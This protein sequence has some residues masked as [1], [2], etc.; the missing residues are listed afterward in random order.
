M[1]QSENVNM[2]VKHPTF[3]APQENF[4]DVAMR[5][6]RYRNSKSPP[7]T[8]P[9]SIVVINP[10]G[11]Q[12]TQFIVPAAS[13]L[14]FS[15]SF[16]THQGTVAP[17]ANGSLQLFA[18]GYDFRTINLAAASGYPIVNLE[19]A[20]YYANAIRPIETDMTDF[21]SQ[22]DNTQSFYPCNSLTVSNPFPF[23]VDGSTSGTLN[24]GTT[25]YLE[26]QHLVTFAT[27]ATGSFSRR[28]YLGDL[29]GTFFGCD[30]DS[31]FG[32]DMNVN[33]N[34]QY[35]Q[36]MGYY[37]AGNGVLTQ[38]GA[39]QSNITLTNVNF[40]WALEQ[41]VNIRNDIIN[42][43]RSGGLKMEIPYT[44]TTNQVAAAGASSL[45]YSF[46]ISKN[47][48]RT[49]KRILFV[50]YANTNSGQLSFCHTNANGAVITNFQ[51]SFD[52]KPLTDYYLNCFNPNNTA[53][54]PGVTWSSPP[55]WADDWREA[56]QWLAGKCNFGGYP[57]YQN[58][59]WYADVW[60]I[61][62]SDAMMAKHAEEN[63]LD[64][65]SLKDLGNHT[66]TINASSP[67][68]AQSTNIYNALGVWMFFFNLYTRKLVITADGFYFDDS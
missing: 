41:N 1:A 63:S 22:R 10:N 26:A 7:T 24:S 2:A 65:F 30:R 16:E 53:S 62:Q 48:G 25:A 55:T 13:T 28:N 21:L 33:I 5:V 44:Y 36:R 15:R 45:N 3:L 49:L 58:Q 67:S 19:Y 27:G 12:Q 34:Y 50:P 64:G 29:K 9:S 32:T 14:N 35:G 8:S 17:V 6:P 54:P 37:S 4:M 68:V 31:C 56:Q 42:K 39:I 66:Y 43:L 46:T 57:S 20:D 11:N 51:T 47:Y 52:G 38:T 61:L 23:S 18:D 40:F 59:W 60:G